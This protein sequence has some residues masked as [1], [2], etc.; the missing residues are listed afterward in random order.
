MQQSFTR[1][2]EP[3]TF[4]YSGQEYEAVAECLPSV[5]GYRK[6]KLAFP[7]IQSIVEGSVHMSETPNGDWQIEKIMSA[8]P[9]HEEFLHDI[10][11]GFVEFIDNQKFQ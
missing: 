3:F 11:Q 9:I 10:A 6:Y 7:N 1:N 2:G 5:N 8:D 4:R